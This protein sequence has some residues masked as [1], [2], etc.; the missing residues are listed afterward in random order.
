[1]FFLSTLVAC[2]YDE[3]NFLTKMESRH[4]KNKELKRRRLTFE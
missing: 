4:Y 2:M 3:L 1:M